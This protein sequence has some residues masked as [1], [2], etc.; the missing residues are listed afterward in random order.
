MNLRNLICCAVALPFLLV[1]PALAQTDPRVTQLEEQ[2][3]RLQ[4]TIEELNF[5]ILQMQDQM[6]RM[7][8]D[9]EFR[10]QEIEQGGSGIGG[11]RTPS[12][13]QQGSLPSLSTS[14]ETSSIIIDDDDVDTT[15]GTPP[16]QFGTIV[17]D[18][19][20]QV[21][22]S[23]VEEQPATEPRQLPSPSGQSEMAALPSGGDADSLYRDSYDFILSGDYATAEAGFRRFLERHPGDPNEADARFWLGEALLAQDRHRDA[24]EV[25]LAAS[26]D[27]PDSRKAPDMLFKL[28]TSLAA[29]NQR[30]VACATYAEVARRYPQASDALMERVRQGQSAASC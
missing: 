19:H 10:F 26:R 29:L 22:G 15:L 1:G 5:Q 7:Q 21:V 4:G 11:G 17:F 12:I 27:F 9:F 2:L 23:S 18:A 20:G 25:F 30:E 6:R 14:E 24:A 13:G 3:R 28:A 8:E 16:R